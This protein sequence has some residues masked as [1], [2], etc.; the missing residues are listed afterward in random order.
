MRPPREEALIIEK[1]PDLKKRKKSEFLVNKNIEPEE[2]TEKQY[3]M[4]EI[5][6]NNIE[7]LNI[8]VIKILIFCFSF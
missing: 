8:G 5:L 7:Q 6:K 1:S 2:Q 3:T 4:I